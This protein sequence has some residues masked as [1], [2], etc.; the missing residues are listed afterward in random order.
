[1]WLCLDWLIPL[2]CGKRK[3]GPRSSKS[4]TDASSDSCS[5]SARPAHQSPKLS[6]YSTSHFMTQVC[7]RQNI[8]STECIDAR[9]RKSRLGKFDERNKADAN[10]GADNLRSTPS[11]SNDSTFKSC[12]H[13]LWP[14]KLPKGAR[15]TSARPARSQLL[16]TSPWTMPWRRLRRGKL[17]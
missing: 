1:M 13:W 10:I 12:R 6:V 11:S 14:D 2:L 9:D 7:S 5:S 17:R 8:P 3:L 15:A 16:A 4:R